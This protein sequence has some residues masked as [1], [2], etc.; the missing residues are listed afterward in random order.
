MNDLIPLSTHSLDD[1]PTQTV[2]ARDL[3]AFLEVGKDFSNWIK[4]R[5][6]QFGF[7]ENQDF[8]LLANFGEQKTDGR[9]GHNRK[10]YYLTLDMAKEL[11]M[12]ERT[13]KGK[14]ARLYFIE[15]EKRLHGKKK[16][17]RIPPKTPVNRNLPEGITLAMIRRDVQELVRIGRCTM[18]KNQAFLA[19][20]EHESRLIGFNIRPL[21][22]SSFLSLPSVEQSEVFLR[23]TDI[24]ER[25]G[26]FGGTGKP[27]ARFANMLLER[28]GIQVRSVHGDGDWQPTEL[29]KKFSHWREVPKAG[30][31]GGRSI[32][33]LFW[34]ES[35]LDV[36]RELGKSDKAN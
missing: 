4:D 2:N 13:A 6:Q 18:D 26:I 1:T 36:L 33:Q 7:V 14:E 30:I 21:L 3:H 9:G 25:L 20:I 23:P 35:V 27:D 31:I 12:V 24:A 32:R 17:R 29:G 16:T 8:I 15:C 22:P 28:A 10:E 5:I 34:K 19:A 11:S